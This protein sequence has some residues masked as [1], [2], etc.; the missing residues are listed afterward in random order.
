VPAYLDLFAGPGGWD[1]GVRALGIAPLGIEWDA[2]ACA[3][4]EAAGHRRL[5]ADVAALDPAAFGPVRGLIASPPCQGFSMAGKGRGRDDSVHMVKALAD[6]TGGWGQLEAVLADLHA[7]MAD[8]RSLLALEPLRWCL[9]LDPDWTAWEQVPT[10]LPLWEACADVLRRRGYSVA[11]GRLRAEQYGV[12][13]TRSRAVLVARS[14]Q[15]SDD[16][17]PAQLPVPTHSRYRPRERDRMDPGL[18]PWVSMAEALGWGMTER[19]YPTMASGHRDPA[20][21]GG[22]AA[23]SLVG[24]ERDAGRWLYQSGLSAPGFSRGVRGRAVRPAEDPARTITTRANRDTWR[25]ASG[26]RS[27]SAVRDVDEPAPTL[28][29]GHDSASYTFV[30]PGTEAEGVAAAKADGSAVRV[31][32]QEAAVLQSFRWDYPWQG[33]RT[34]VFEQIGNAVPPLLARAIIAAVAGYEEETWQHQA[35]PAKTVWRRRGTPGCAVP[36]RHRTPGHAA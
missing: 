2:A 27:R 26:T 36:A 32:T 31:T 24:G 15:L 20:F 28:A 19:P 10:V 9:E 18:L 33:T 25:L 35:A 23:R 6:V 30:P 1:E 22:S 12:P 14:P 3:T 34:K 21:L 16:L 5:C 8:D 17:G 11:T 7:T 13:Q 4:A 29:P